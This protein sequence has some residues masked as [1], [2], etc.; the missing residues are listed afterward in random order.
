MNKRIAWESWGEKEKDWCKKN[1]SKK[2]GGSLDH[3]DDGEEDGDE[4]EGY[5]DGGFAQDGLI[6]GAISGGGKNLY[7]PFG[8][9]EPDCMLK[10]SDRWECWLGHANFPLTKKMGRILNKQIDGIAALSII[11]GYT[12][13]VGIAKMYDWALVRKEIED[14]ILR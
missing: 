10:P 14:K 13:C 3:D 5:K 6:L 4:E 12:F 7:T 9:Y 8:V 11:D 1:S 2:F